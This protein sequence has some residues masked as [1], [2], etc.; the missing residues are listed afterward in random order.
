MINT[1]HRGRVEKHVAHRENESFWEFQ[2]SLIPISAG[3]ELYSLWV[4]SNRRK[5]CD[6]EEKFVAL[7]ANEMSEKIFKWWSQ[8]HTQTVHDN[9]TYHFL[10]SAQPKEPIERMHILVSFSLPSDLFHTNKNKIKYQKQKVEIIY[11]T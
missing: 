5:V 4:V 2:F 11:R 9:K 7:Q 6:C 1:K 3:R 10:C 8:W